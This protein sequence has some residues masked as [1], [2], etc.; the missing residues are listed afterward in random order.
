MPLILPTTDSDVTFTPASV[1]ATFK[2][3]QTQEA[4]LYPSMPVWV[5]APPVLADEGYKVQI[6][7]NPNLANVTLVGPPDVIAQLRN[8]TLTPRPQAHIEVSL[9]DLPAGTTKTRQVEYGLPDGV[10][11]APEDAARTVDF[12]LVDT[13]T[14]A[15]R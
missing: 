9:T 7:S 4:Y 15:G 5:L 10:H 12:K 2:V 11:V 14:G 13:G 6:T 8:G 3:K 1:T